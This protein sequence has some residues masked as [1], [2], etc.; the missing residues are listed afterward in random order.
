MIG[1]LR[2]D[3]YMIWAYCRMFLLMVAIFLVVSCLGKDE[4]G[5]FTIYPMIIGMI[6][7]VSLISYDER[8]KWHVACD[9]M[10]VSRE[11]AVSSKYLLTLLSVLVVGALSM[12]AQGI[13][14]SRVGELSALWELPGLLLPIGL[15]APALLLPAIFRLGV[16][17][18]RI[19]YFVLVG[20]VC[21]AGVMLGTGTRAALRVQG[22][23]APLLCL[24]SV[25]IFALS[26]LLSIFLYQRREL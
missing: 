26:W 2:K 23:S 19:F 6:I 24:A 25:V 9:A 18:G 16:E 4:N 15:I 14:L 12:L 13:R 22:I 11:M 7:P 20:V 1:L 21:A 10:P 17:R 3:L 8:F 5:F